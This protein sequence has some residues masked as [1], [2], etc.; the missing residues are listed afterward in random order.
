M[1][2]DSIIFILSIKFIKLFFKTFMPYFKVILFTIEYINL[3]L[4]I[5][6][7]LGIIAISIKLYK[8]YVRSNNKNVHLNLGKNNTNNPKKFNECTPI[9]NSTIDE[10]QPPQTNLALIF[11]GISLIINPLAIFSILG[12]IYG[13]IQLADKNNRTEKNW[14]IISIIASVLMIILWIFILKNRF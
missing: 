7:I 2:L 3:I 11:T 10:N 9:V 13:I 4:I 12:L 8:Q 5:Y 6:F 14:T 1:N